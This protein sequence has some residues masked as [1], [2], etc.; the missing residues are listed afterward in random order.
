M[1]MPAFGR[2]NRASPLS[3]HLSQ[4]MMSR[5][6]LRQTQR[7]LTAS[8]LSHGAPPRARPFV[9]LLI[10]LC[11]SCHGVTIFFSQRTV[12]EYQRPESE[13]PPQ[14]PLTLTDLF[15]TPEGPPRAQD[16]M[17]SIKTDPDLHVPDAKPTSSDESVVEDH[18]PV[19]TDS[20]GDLSEGVGTQPLPTPD[21]SLALIA[22]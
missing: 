12:V 17:P 8:C 22:S 4:V 7:S 2:R 15:S 10:H 5:T 11:R 21:K 13:F 3:C 1:S 18:N 16:D 19:E 20:D 14:P 6:R 9:H